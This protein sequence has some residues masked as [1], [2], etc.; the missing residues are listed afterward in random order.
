[1]RENKVLLNIAI[2]FALTFASEDETRHSKS[3]LKVMFVT[4]KR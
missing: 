3:R 4:G 1:M 2:L